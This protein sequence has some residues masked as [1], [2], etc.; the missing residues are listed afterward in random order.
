MVE[1][2]YIFNQ[3][4]P[5]GT[6]SK[7]DR[8]FLFEWSSS[9]KNQLVIFGDILLQLNKSLPI[10]EDIVLHTVRSISRSSKRNHWHLFYNSFFQRP[11][12]DWALD[13]TCYIFVVISLEE[14][15]IDIPGGEG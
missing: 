13:V 11:N 9:L 2:I 5:V 6:C 10:L 4:K 8:L 7:G 1:N 15:C 3:I 12:C 14:C